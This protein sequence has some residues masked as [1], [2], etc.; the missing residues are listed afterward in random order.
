VGAQ[1]PLIARRQLTQLAALLALSSASGCGRRDQSAVLAELVT[2]VVLGMA[3]EMRAESVALYAALRALSNEPSPERQRAAQ[4]AFKRATLAWKQA[5]AFRSGPFVSSEAFQRAAFWPARATSIDAV[6]AGAE[7]IDEQRIE[8]LGVDARGLF[9]L[10]YLLFD[11]KNAQSLGIASDGHGARARAYALEL[12][13]NVRGYADR[14]QRLLGGDGRSYAASFAQA[15]QRSIDALVA[16]ALDTL[17]IVCGKFARIE[18]ARREGVPLPFAVEGY[19]SGS[20]LEIVLAILAGTE[21]LYS[22]SSSSSS[23][24][25]G[26]SGG[27]GGLSELVAAASKPIDAHVHAMFRDARQGL[28]ALAA[29]LEVALDTQPERFRS[30]AAAVTELRHV[31]EVEMQSALSS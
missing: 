15:G 25:A 6:L 9:A 3:R 5:Y 12:A 18:R 4:A 24:G 27:R 23:G 16:Q 17:E 13:A 1:R 10:E 8:G 7:A 14:V 11:P 26:G 30:A 22:G 28:R 19:F 2:T 20:S 21:L 29:P 31:L